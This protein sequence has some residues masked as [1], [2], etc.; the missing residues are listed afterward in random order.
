VIRL[1]GAQSLQIQVPSDLER[2]SIDEGKHEAYVDKLR[3][4]SRLDC[5]YL[6]NETDTLHAALLVPKAILSA[7][8]DCFGKKSPNLKCR[9]S[10]NEWY[11]RECKELQV[12]YVG[13][14]ESGAGAVL[15]FAARRL[16]RTLVR[17][18]KRQYRLRKYIGYPVATPKA[19]GKGIGALESLSASDTK[20]PG[21]LTFLTSFP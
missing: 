4:D 19:F 21:T 11:D 6:K 2:I 10:S 14:V 5:Q 17:S 15:S 1:P 3:N 18:K 16:Y 20:T 7:A 12:K 9:F 8:T 13:L